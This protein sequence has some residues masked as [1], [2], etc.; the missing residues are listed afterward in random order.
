MIAFLVLR[1]WYAL[2]ELGLYI[3][4]GTWSLIYP[5]EIRTFCAQTTTPD[6][7]TVLVLHAT[8]LR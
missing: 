8:D 6:M 4:F 3:H 5:L 1:L 7:P 2:E